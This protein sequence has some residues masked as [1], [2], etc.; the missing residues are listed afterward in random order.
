MQDHNYFLFTK[1]YD[2]TIISRCNCKEKVEKFD[3]EKEYKKFFKVKKSIVKKRKKTKNK[4]L[5]KTRFLSREEITIILNIKSDNQNGLYEN[6][7]ISQNNF[8][9]KILKND[10]IKMVS[11]KIIILI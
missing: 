8:C 7:Q 6:I 9:K 5:F 4:L 10:N 11:L 3:V 1:Q 2:H